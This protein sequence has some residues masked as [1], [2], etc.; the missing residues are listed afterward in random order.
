M[1]DILLITK[2]PVQEAEEFAARAV[3][4]SPPYPSPYLTMGSVFIIEG[5]EGEA[6]EFFRKAEAR[7]ADDYLIPFSKAR[8]YL[9]KGEKEKVKILLEEVVSSKDTPEALRKSISAT[10]GAM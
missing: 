6:E 1:A 4:N 7:G 9:L 5:K 2:E 8:A 3:A 10:L